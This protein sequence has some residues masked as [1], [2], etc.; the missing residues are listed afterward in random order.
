[1]GLNKNNKFIIKSELILNNSISSNND[2]KKGLKIE[3]S[4]F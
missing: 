2:N 1:M 4:I 3:T